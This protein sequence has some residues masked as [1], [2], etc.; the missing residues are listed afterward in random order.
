MPFTKSPML[1]PA[2]F[3]STAV[4]AALALALPAAVHAQ[5][6]G[7]APATAQAVSEGTEFN[8]PAGPL[9]ATLQAIAKTSG[10]RVQFEEADVQGLKAP[11]IS[12]KTSSQGA[13]QAAISGSGLT[14]NT[15]PDGSIRVF[16]Q[17]LAAVAVTAKRDEA[18]TG[19]R[20]SSS[21]TATRGG[22][23]LLDVPQSVTVLTAKVLETQQSASVEDALRN[24]AGVVTI[25]ATQGGS[26]FNIRGFATTA[27]TLSNGLT[28]PDSYKTNIAGVERI[29]ILKGPQALLAGANSLGGT[30]NIVTRKPTTERIRD[31]SVSY[32]SHAERTGTIDLAGAIN[33]SKEFSY[34]VIGS[35]TRANGSDAGYDGRSQD[36]GLGELR[37][38][39]ADTD[40]IFGA[41][42]SKTH[43]PLGRYTVAIR[44]FIE[45]VPSTLPGNRSDGVDTETHSVFYTLQHSFSDKLQF[46]SR[47]QRAS[48]DQDLNLWTPQFPVSVP[49]LLLSYSGTIN[50]SNQTTTSGDHYLSYKFKT[51]PLDQNLVAG[52]NH[53]DY[54]YDLTQYTGPRVSVPFSQPTQYPFPALER[55]DASRSFGSYAPQTQRGLYVQDT[56]K[57]DKWTLVA[58][59]RHSS[60]DLGPGS[61][62]VYATP[63]TTT[64]SAQRS[65]SK[66]TVNAGLIYNLDWNTSI[67]GSYAEGFTP[68]FSDLSICGTNS[69]ATPPTL[70]KSK[71]LGIK[72]N[73]DDRFSWSAAVFQLDQTNLLRRNRPLN[74]NDLIDGQ[75]SQ[76]VELEASGQPMRG[77]NL[78]FNYS[79]NKRKSLSDP[80]ARPGLGPDSQASVWSTY[81]FQSEPLRG[82]GLAFG[83]SA[84]GDSRMGFTDS[85]TRLPGG[86]RIDA[87]ISYTQPEWSLRLG[88]KNLADRTLYATTSSTMYVPL[89][90][91]RTYTLT[92]QHKF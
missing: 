84:W 20:A 43:T 47:M 80:T 89:Y 62:V 76:G 77:L 69:T 8:I 73:V 88:V 71:E 57:W 68:L 45:P 12:A 78:I 15:G 11:A 49:N 36:Y 14:M 4:C 54:S 55:S 58:G 39:N 72:S 3:R 83:I 24:V 66:N 90:D 92:Y 79:Y 1:R 82:V 40:V 42:A 86:A 38:K 10:K 44:G 50:R 35:A 85:A 2:P 16:V 13:I 5:Q 19:F 33:D 17:Q 23:D 60:M 56:V 70:S 65:F 18:E 48:T 25:P 28:D 7:P 74:C 67:Y 27:A 32:G 31:V 53:T 87:G 91:R 22:A 34:R 75:R 6:A 37:W 21:S 41:S 61:T 52:V 29:E 63:P 30:L 51:G 59:L 26:G 46:T 9:S 81:D 64:T